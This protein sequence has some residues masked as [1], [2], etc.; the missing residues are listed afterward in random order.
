[1]RHTAG[2][3]RRVAFSPGRSYAGRNAM[4]GWLAPARIGMIQTANERGAVRG[5]SF[6]ARAGVEGELPVS[7]DSDDA[8]LTIGPPSRVCVFVDFWNLALSLNADA[9]TH[10]EQPWQLDWLRFPAW[11]AA[12]AARLCAVERHRHVGTFVYSS[13]NNGSPGQLRH[14]N[15][16]LNWLGRQP[17]VTVELRPQVRRS[18]RCRNCGAHAPPCPRCGYSTDK[19]MERALMR[20]SPR[21]CSSSS[22]TTATTS[23]RWSRPM[24]TWRLWR[25]FSCDA[26]GWSCRRGL[27]SRAGC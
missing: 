16:A 9:A 6:I 7:T 4:S 23:R 12:E 11:V 2:S 20:R 1:M 26:V 8:E 15:W 24:V 10:G 17:D 19:M 14:R 13:F 5:P 3:R 27:G 21:A 18:D 22:L 25:S